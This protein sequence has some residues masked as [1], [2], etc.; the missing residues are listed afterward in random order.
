MSCVSFFISTKNWFLFGVLLNSRRLFFLIGMICPLCSVV[1]LSFT[2]V[3]YFPKVFNFSI[4]FI[5]STTAPSAIYVVSNA[6]TPFLSY[7]KGLCF[8]V[9][10]LNFWILSQSNFSPIILYYFIMLFLGMVYVKSRKLVLSFMYNKVTI[11]KFFSNTWYTRLK[12]NWDSNMYWNPSCSLI[13]S[14]AKKNILQVVWGSLYILERFYSI[15]TK[16]CRTKGA[17]NE[18]MNNRKAKVTVLYCFEVILH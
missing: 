9:V 14:K 13:L 6:Y 3:S 1:S 18:S 5:L 8:K 2:N 15:L 12:R 10:C 17:V 7:V 11:Y 16:I 4:L